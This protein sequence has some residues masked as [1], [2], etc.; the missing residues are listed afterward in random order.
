M[1][2]LSVA[3][4]AMFILMA[5]TL[6]GC[7]VAPPEGGDYGGREGYYDREHYRDEEHRHHYEHHDEGR[8]GERHDERRWEDEEHH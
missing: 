3:M 5:A 8:G 6:G 1:K 4:A 7:V 2:T